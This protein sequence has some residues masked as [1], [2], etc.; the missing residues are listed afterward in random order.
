LIL[1]KKA[2]KIGQGFER[3]T[4]GLKLVIMFLERLQRLG[5]YDNSIIVLVG[6]HG[7]GFQRFGPIHVCDR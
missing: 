6:D 1:Q 2:P 5:I 4:A 7:A 3:A